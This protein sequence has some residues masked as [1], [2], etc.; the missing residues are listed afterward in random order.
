MAKAAGI[1][2][3]LPWR[4]K[5]EVYVDN[6]DVEPDGRGL[7]I[8]AG[9]QQDSAHAEWASGRHSDGYWL[10]GNADDQASVVEHV[11]RSEIKTAWKADR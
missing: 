3:V 5:D 9:C 6:E 11:G 7:E 10:A 1:V 2:S 4:T 8:C